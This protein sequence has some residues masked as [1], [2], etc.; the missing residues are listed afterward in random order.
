MHQIALPLLAVGMAYLLLQP[1]LDGLTSALAVLP[2]R[3]SP[4]RPRARRSAVR[5]GGPHSVHPLC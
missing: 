3:H 2:W 5:A 1:L 4:T